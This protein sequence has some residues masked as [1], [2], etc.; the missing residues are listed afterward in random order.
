MFKYVE[1]ELRQL[2]PPKGDGEKSKQVTSGTGIIVSARGHIL[3][4]HHV[5]QECQTIE[6]RR[7]GEVTVSASVLHIDESNDLALIKVEVGLEE[8]DVAFIRTT[9]A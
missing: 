9:P 2:E 3:T 1:A 7:P 6:M 8:R 5:V 4:N